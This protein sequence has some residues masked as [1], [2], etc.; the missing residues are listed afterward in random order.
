MAEFTK[1]CLNNNIDI[2]ADITQFTVFKSPEKPTL[3]LEGDLEN[4][5][6]LPEQVKY[7]AEYL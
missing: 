4:L 7:L 2:Y 3:E 1:Y 5:K 6:G